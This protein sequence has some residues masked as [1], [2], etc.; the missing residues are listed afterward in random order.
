MLPYLKSVTIRILLCL[1]ELDNLTKE[2]KRSRITIYKSE[3]DVMVDLL[4]AVG[5]FSKFSPC[6]KSLKFLNLDFQLLKITKQRKSLS[7][8][9][10]F[11]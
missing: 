1:A 3:D 4:F 7:N 10:N 2:I 9:T 11:F 5:I 8:L 6:P